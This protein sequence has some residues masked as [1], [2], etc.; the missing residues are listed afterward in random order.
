MG[1]GFYDNSFA[2]LL[3][4]K[5]WHKPRLIGLAYDFQLMPRLPVQPWDVPLTAVATDSGWYRFRA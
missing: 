5:H 3:H 4:R 2:Y 1:G